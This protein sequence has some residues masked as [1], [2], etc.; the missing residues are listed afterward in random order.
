MIDDC[1]LVSPPVAVGEANYYRGTATVDPAS[2]EVTIET[3][4][5]VSLTGC[6]AE[7]VATEVL[8]AYEDYWSAVTDVLESAGSE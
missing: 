2:G 5:P 3:V 4:E 8:A 1:L 6:I 7:P